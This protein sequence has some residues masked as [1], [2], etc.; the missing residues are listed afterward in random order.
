MDATIHDFREGVFLRDRPMRDCVRMMDEEP[1]KK[2]AE[3]CPKDK[4]A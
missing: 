1:N 3:Q 4:Q 2:D